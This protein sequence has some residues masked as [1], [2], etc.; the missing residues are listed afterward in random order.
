MPCSD[1]QVKNKRSRDL[2]M[3]ARKVYLC[4]G[5]V[6][7]AML[8]GIAVWER[9]WIA[10]PSRAE[11][12]TSGGVQIGKWLREERVQAAFSWNL[13]TQKTLLCVVRQS[14]TGASAGRYG[15]ELSIVNPSGVSLY[16][17]N[18][19][20]VEKIYSIFALRKSPPQLVIEFNEGGNSN[21]LKILDF[22]DGKVVDIS[23]DEPLQFDMGAEVRPQIRNGTNPLR[24]PFE[25]LLRQRL[26]SEFHT[27][28]YRY[29]SGAYAY[30]GEVPEE[31]LGDYMESKI[32]LKPQD[33]K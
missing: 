18:Y 12:L 3:N 7:A 2:D 16:Q 1:L 11:Q 13:D 21:F 28:V 6:L 15:V 27:D 4:S 19:A 17:N 32:A 23:G 24:E 25:I 9:V 5:V 10:Y 14:A 30:V 29:C 33:G 20:A 31:L 8:V 26:G 22:Q